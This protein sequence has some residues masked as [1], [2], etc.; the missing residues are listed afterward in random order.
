[1]DDSPGMG[2]GSVEPATR[3]PMLRLVRRS[4]MP[5]FFNVGDPAAEVRLE[6]RGILVG[7]SFMLFDK[8]FSNDDGGMS[9]G[10][11]EV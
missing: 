8:E 6:I 4:M 7:V 11:L 10:S 2:E 3:L 1:M 5:E 9:F